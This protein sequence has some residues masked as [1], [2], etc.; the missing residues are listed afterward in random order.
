MQAQ[1][2]QIAIKTFAILRGIK[3]PV[4]N[5]P[6]SD[7]PSDAV[8]QLSHRV[9]PLLGI[10]GIPV[11]ILADHNV[12]RQLAPRSWNLA[13]GLLKQSLPVLILDRRTTQLPLDG[14]EG[15][16]HFVRA[17]LRFNFEP[18][19]I[20]SCF[21]RRSCPRATFTP[22]FYGCHSLVRLLAISG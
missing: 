13:I 18:A 22:H 7:G 12:G 5:A 21:V 15:I 17:E 19:A 10:V 11:E 16:C 4:G 9:L 8:N 6:I 20:A 2:S 3:V 1:P 14:V